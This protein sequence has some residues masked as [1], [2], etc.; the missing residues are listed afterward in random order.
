MRIARPRVA[1]KAVAVRVLIRDGYGVFGARLARLLLRD[2][3]E[4][5]RW[6]GAM[7]AGKAQRLADE[8]G[9]A[10]LRV[11]QCKDLHLLVVHQVAV[12][13]AGP[14]QSYGD[15]PC[16]LPPAAIAAGIR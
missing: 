16:H 2:G 11:Y 10:A 1:E 5:L 6:P 12:D 14:F 8:L 15:D 3:H 9:C 4:R 13:A 7:P